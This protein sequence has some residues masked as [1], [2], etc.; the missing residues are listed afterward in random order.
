M[1]YLEEE[2]EFTF[3]LFWRLCGGFSRREVASVTFLAPAN[4]FFSEN[5]L[6]NQNNLLCQFLNF[7]E[8]QARRPVF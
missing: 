1:E 5:F 8:P 4:R 7:L 2:V 3:T 6:Q